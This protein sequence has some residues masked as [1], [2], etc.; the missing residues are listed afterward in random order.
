MAGRKGFVQVVGG[1]VGTMEVGWFVEEV[2]AVCSEGAAVE[3]G[4]QGPE[5]RVGWVFVLVVGLESGEEEPGAGVGRDIAV[6][7][8]RVVGQAVG[9]VA[10]VVF[11]WEEAVGLRNEATTKERET[12]RSPSIERCQPAGRNH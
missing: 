5:V 3:G 10:G 9:P 2:G 6:L 1:G 8:E 7:V 12:Q 4:G 11:G